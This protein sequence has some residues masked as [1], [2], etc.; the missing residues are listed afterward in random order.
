MVDRES[1][2]I[3]PVMAIESKIESLFFTQFF[4]CYSS[5]LVSVSSW[6]DQLHFLESCDENGYLRRNKTG[7]ITDKI[8][9]PTEGTWECNNDIIVSWILKLVSKEIVASIVDIRS[10]KVVWDE[11]RDRFKQSN[12]HSIYQFHKEMVTLRKGTMSVETYY[13]KLKTIWQDLTDYRPTTE[14]TSG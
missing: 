13:T 8:K 1:R 14:C 3:D 2:R 12:D 9:K 10:V 5:I 4:F 7:F 11:L 6:H